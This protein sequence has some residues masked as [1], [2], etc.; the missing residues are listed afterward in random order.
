MSATRYLARLRE[1]NRSETRLQGT[2]QTAK[3]NLRTLCSSPAVQKESFLSSQGEPGN[4]PNP[5]GDLLALVDHVAAVRG[6][7][8]ADKAE[9]VQDWRACPD[10]IEAG[11]GHLLA[12]Y[13]E[14]PDAGQRSARQC[15]HPVGSP[16]ASGEVR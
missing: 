1:K 13:G 10:H 2:A 12:F 3:K 4:L 16:D 11:L 8:E 5:S 15:L 14:R 7:S 9:T 6:W